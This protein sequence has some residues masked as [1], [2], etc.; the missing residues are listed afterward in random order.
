MRCADKRPRRRFTS[1]SGTC[2]RP[3]HAVG[4]QYPHPVDVKPLTEEQKWGNFRAQ[5]DV[6]DNYLQGRANKINGLYAD[7]NMNKQHL[8]SSGV[9]L[10]HLENRMN[11]AIK[12]YEIKHTYVWANR[13]N[14]RAK[15]DGLVYRDCYCDAG[16][17]GK[18]PRWIEFTKQEN[19][20]NSLTQEYNDIDG[21]NTSRKKKVDKFVKYVNGVVSLH[22]D[23]MSQQHHRKYIYDQRAGETV[24][25]P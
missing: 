5:I 6:W 16:K 13:V 7:L 17:W 14:P 11:D 24:G 25:I 19:Y 20:K 2:Q 10:G 18:T 4:Q 21:G 23:Q 3:L 8:S 15:F 9:A 22:N 12:R 1:S